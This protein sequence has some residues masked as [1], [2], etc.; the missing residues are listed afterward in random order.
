MILV[1]L[2]YMAH[3]RAPYILGSP[4]T[5]GK[6]T[7][8][9]VI[10][11]VFVTFVIMLQTPRETKLF[12]PA[13]SAAVRDIL[14]GVQSVPHI[15]CWAVL[16]YIIAGTETKVVSDVRKCVSHVKYVMCVPHR[17]WYHNIRVKRTIVKQCE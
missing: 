14:G 5:Q 9:H 15:C 8:S 16:G 1:A 12:R 10:L 2:G 6:P 17:E 3:D 7:F 13:I 11:D 4:Y